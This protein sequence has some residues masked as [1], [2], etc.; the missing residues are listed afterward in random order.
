M[1]DASNFDPTS[2]AKLFVNFVIASGLCGALGRLS[3]NQISQRICGDP[4]LT[5]KWIAYLN[6]CASYPV[7]GPVCAAAARFVAFTVQNSIQC[8]AFA[9]AIGELVAAQLA[10]I[11]STTNP[12]GPPM[13]CVNNHKVSSTVQGAGTCCSAL[14]KS[15][16]APAVGVRVAATDSKGKCFICEIKASTSPKHRGSLVFKRGKASGPGASCPTSQ[17]GCCILSTAS[18]Q[19]V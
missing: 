10:S 2:L 7:V 8:N 15:G 17:Q 4:S 3:G 11:C 1:P 14:S 19:T 16:I 12:G 13:A 5:R 6:Q 18:Q 9:S